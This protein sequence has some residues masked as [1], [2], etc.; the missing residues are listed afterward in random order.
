MSFFLLIT[1]SITYLFSVTPNCLY[2]RSVRKVIFKFLLF[3]S[4]YKIEQLFYLVNWSFRE[5]GL[6]VLLDAYSTKCFK[7]EIK[8]VI[9]LNMYS[10]Y[11]VR[12]INNRPFLIF[13]IQLVNLTGL[14]HKS[15]WA[16][17][18][19]FH[20]HFLRRIRI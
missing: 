4:M 18:G 15:C 20:S 2:M 3:W 6:M 17:E 7:Y 11:E 8:N 9:L 16:T 14:H 13:I 19:P 12:S 1:L 10:N 5:N